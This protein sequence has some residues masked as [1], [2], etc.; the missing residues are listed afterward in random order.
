MRADASAQFAPIFEGEPTLSVGALALD[1]STEPEPTLYVG[2]GE[3]DNSADSYYGDGIFVSSDLGATWI[4]LGAADIS[5][6][7]VMSIAIDASRSPRVIYAAVSYG[8]SA[9]RAD[10]SWVE[11]DFSQNGLWRSSD[12][13]ATWNQYPLGTFGSCPYFTDAPCPAEQVVGDSTDSARVYVSI[14]GTGV[15]CSSDS[16]NTWTQASFPAIGTRGVGRA[17]IAASG[18]TV[19]AMVGASDGIEYSGFYKSTDAGVSWT[20]ETVPQATVGQGVIIDGAGAGD[21]SQSLFGQALTIDPSDSSGDTVVFGGVGIYRST[22]SG[23]SWTFL[24]AGGGT[25]SEQHAIAFDPSA[26]YSFILGNDGGLYRFDAS[27]RSWSALNAT[28]GAAQIQSLGPHP[29][30]ANVML[31]GLQDN[32]TARFDGT[33]PLAAAWSEVDGLGGGTAIFDPVD[34]TY[35][36]DTFATT[37]SGPALARSTDSGATWSASESTAALRAAMSTALDAGAAYYPPLAA[38]PDRAERVLFGAHSIYVSTDGMLTW[39][40]QTTQDLTGGCSSGACALEDIEVA[41]SDDSKAYALAMETSITTRPTPFRL[42][43]TAQANVQVD[44]SDPG[45]AQWLD[46]TA[47]LEPM[48]F[49]DQTQATAVAIDPFDYRTAYLA[50]S[51]FTAAT[52]IGHIFVTHDFGQ[53]WMQADGNPADDIPPPAGALPDVPV[54]RLLVDRNDSTGATVLAATD[55]GVFRTTDGG[56]TWAAFDLGAIGAVPVI[57]VQQNLAG[58]IFA[59][60]NG[61]GVYE[62]QTSSAPTPTSTATPTASATST[63]TA[64]SSATST[65]TPSPTQTPSPTPTPTGTPTPVPSPTPIATPTA[66]PSPTPTPT[67]ARTATPA[68]TATPAPIT[69][70]L[71]VRPRHVRFPRQIVDASGTSGRYRM[72]KLR[73]RS[74]DSIAIESVTITG[75]FSIAAGASTCPATLAP[76]QRC[77]IAVNFMPKASGRRTGSLT[78]TDN[79]RNSPQTVKLSGKGAQ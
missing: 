6:A 56:A 41:P 19:Y 37:A 50:V 12:G 7:A 28:I 62:L 60:T 14:L 38:D 77:A 63:P 34:P 64:T 61:R 30:D 59:G 57:D 53:S 78:I 73:N 23:A 11:S 29:T 54:L 21:F 10:A 9:N 79:A 27:S 74:A 69:G 48:L 31:A 40:R 1:T 33:A 35:A 51:G 67:V 18:A 15:F 22:D 44:A 36:Y 52:G 65:P 20:T 70:A 26:A 66:A 45:G 58:T 49:P 3:G 5:H 13:G 17:S 55:S 71:V 43:T 32:G 76:H 72:I 8:S 24:A 75:D 4:Q 25:H 2:T 16:G 47:N 68:A 46:V 42:F 39:A